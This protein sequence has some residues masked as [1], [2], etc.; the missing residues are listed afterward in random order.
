MATFDN[1]RPLVAA[2]A[3][4][5]SRACLDTTTGLLAQ[6]GIGVD[7]DR[8][9]LSQSAAAA[10]LAALEAEYESAYLLTMA[11]AWMADNGHPNSMEASM[12]LLEPASSLSACSLSC[13]SMS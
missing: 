8:P 6:R 3:V 12:A 9:P 7:W 2:M 4:G 5:L 10:R 13:F 1:T 11:A